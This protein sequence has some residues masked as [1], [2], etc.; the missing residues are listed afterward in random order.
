MDEDP[1]EADSWNPAGD[2][3]NPLTKIEWTHTLGS[4]VTAV[5]GAGLR[6]DT[7]LELPDTDETRSDYGIEYGVK[8]RP[9]RIILAATKTGEK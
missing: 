1:S 3:G 8:G 2:P 6:I 4:L 5:A 9:G 7:L